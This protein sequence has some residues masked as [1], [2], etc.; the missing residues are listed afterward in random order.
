MAARIK[1]GDEVVVISGKDK[2]KT[3]KVLEVYP[4]DQR[5]LIEGVNM[6]KRHTRPR[7]PK[8]PGGVIDKPA[9]M[10]LSNI[11]LIDPKDKRPTRIRWRVEDGK[12]VR[13]AVRSGEK[14]D[15]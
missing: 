1:A 8:V 3:G 2:G 9:P 15:G 7:P 14:I 10:H 11:A 5:V 12:K 6:I 4:K 13:V